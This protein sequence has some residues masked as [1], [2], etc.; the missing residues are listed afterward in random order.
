MMYLIPKLIEVK[1]LVCWVYKR[2]CK[3]Y[4]IICKET[5][6]IYTSKKNSLKRGLN[7]A[8]SLT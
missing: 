4:N 2:S 5:S 8:E 1:C 3:N 6:S 7:Y